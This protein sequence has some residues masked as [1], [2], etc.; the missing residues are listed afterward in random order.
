MTVQAVANHA[1]DHGC[2]S[3]PGKISQEDEAG[4][5]CHAIPNNSDGC[6]DDEI[7]NGLEGVA[8][9]SPMGERRN[10]IAEH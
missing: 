4:I 5:G 10:T 1:D 7:N 2:A 6:Q 8:S 9:V 3:G